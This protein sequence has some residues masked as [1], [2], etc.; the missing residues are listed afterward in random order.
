MRARWI[1]RLQNEEADA[2]TN[3]DFRHFRPER[4]IEVKLDNLEFVVMD[5]LFE[6]G[7]R[8]VAELEKLKAEENAAG[9]ITARALPRKLARHEPL[10]ERDP[11]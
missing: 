4:R 1:P 11:W 6:E 7:E 2:L 10:R 9:Q 8:Y 3:S 5:K